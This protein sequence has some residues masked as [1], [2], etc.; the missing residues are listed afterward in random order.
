MKFT[1]NSNEL[2]KMLVSASRVINTRNTLPILDNFKISAHEGFSVTASD[3]E[4]TIIVS[5]FAEV[6]EAGETCIPARV[7]TELVRGIDDKPLTFDIDKQ[8]QITWEGGSFTLPVFDVGDYPI[9]VNEADNR[10]TLSGEVLIDALAKT[11]YAAGDDPLRPV[12]NGIFLDLENGHFVASDA[13]KLVMY[14]I[15]PVSGCSLI[16]SK[17]T[18]HLLRNLLSPTPVDVE[19]NQKS[20]VFR[21]GGYVLTSRLVEG[22]FPN[23]KSVI[24]SNPHRL[25]INRTAFLSVIRRVGV[26]SSEANLVRLKITGEKVVVSAQDFDY[27]ISAQEEISCEYLGEDMEIGFKGALLSEVLSNM[28]SERVQVALQSKDKPAIFTPMN[29]Q[30]VLALLTPMMIQ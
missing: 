9:N 20:V 4:N 8:A 30:D 18:A 19:Y 11:F 28:D 15:T 14:G 5:G 25:E 12:M 1:I 26:C 2:T 24:P 21:F 6:S 29:D 17:K 10:I 23:Y 27:G 16:I 3:M 13:H 7:L 22:N